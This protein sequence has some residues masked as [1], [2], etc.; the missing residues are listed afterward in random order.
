MVYQILIST[1]YLHFS[2]FVLVFMIVGLVGEAVV[3][4]EDFHP[5]ILPLFLSSDNNIK[6]ILLIR[7]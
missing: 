4:A 6:Y 3:T 1:M 2:N 5:L 7:L